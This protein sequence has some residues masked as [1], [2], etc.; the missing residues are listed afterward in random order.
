MHLELPAV[1]TDKLRRYRNQTLRQSLRRSWFHS[2]ASISVSM[3]VL[4]AMDRVVALPPLLRGIFW[5][6]CAV[7]L[8]LGTVRLIRAVM[9]LRS[10]IHIARSI[11]QRDTLFGDH[12][13][14]AIELADS[15]SEQRRSMRLCSAALQQVADEAAKR[16]LTRLLPR[17]SLSISRRLLF[18]SAAVLI[19]FTLFFPHVVTNSMHRVIAPFAAIKRQTLVQLSHLD[20]NIVVPRGEAIRW[21][22]TSAPESRWQPDS[23]SLRLGSLGTINSDRS[24]DGYSF[25]FP[26]LNAPID[27]TLRIGDAT[28]TLHLIPKERPQVNSINATIELPSYLQ[29]SQP[30]LATEPSGNVIEA[31]EGAALTLQVNTSTDLS[32][33]TVDGR[34][35]NAAG[36]SFTV[37][38][39]GD[40]TSVMLDWQ[41]QDGLTADRPITI[42]IERTVDQ[43]PTLIV[44]ETNIPA[45]VLNQQQLR[46]RLTAEDDYAVR[47]VGIQWS[48]EDETGERIVGPGPDG[49]NTTA[50]FNPTAYGVEE[51]DVLIRFWV[52]DDLPER[53]RIYTDAYA[54]T[55]LSAEDHAVWIGDSLARWRQSAIEVRDRELQLLSI[56]QELMTVPESDRDVEWRRR[57]ATQAAAEAENSRRLK[58]IVEDGKAILSQAAANDQIPSGQ[59]EGLAQSI[60]ALTDLAEG[61]MPRVAKLLNDAAQEE[62]KFGAMANLETTQGELPDQEQTSS[63][64]DP[65]GET[66]ASPE[67]LGLADTTVIDTSTSGR[68]TDDEEKSPGSNK[69][70]LAEAVEDQA[71]LVAKF[72]AIADQLKELL[73]QMDGSTLVKRMKAISRIQD[74]VAGRLAK[75]IGDRFGRSQPAQPT[76]FQASIDDTEETISRLQRV[77]DDLQA[78]LK[79][80][81]IRSFKVVF[82]EM[83]NDGVLDQLRL[84]KR[85]LPSSPGASIAAAEFWS[86]NFDRLADDLIEPPTNDDEQ[87]PDNGK[88]KK[89]LDPEVVLE[90]LRIL[91]SEVDLRELTRQAEQ[92]RKAMKPDDYASE[93]IQLSESQDGIRDRLDQVIDRLQTDRDS[94]IQFAAEAEVLSSARA[95][96]VD[97]AETLVQPD[98]GPAVIAAQTEAIELLLRSRKVD[99]S[100]GGGS[101]SASSAGGDTDQAALKLVGDALNELAEIR[102]GEVRTSTGAASFEVPERMRADLDRY[103]FR[104]EQRLRGTAK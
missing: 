96:M 94:A 90:V 53:P 88:P 71:E 40:A 65:D 103:F 38:L 18:A 35:I 28:A 32:D 74:R 43:P 54:L 6:T 20:P 31:L 60:G 57:L 1:L 61:R 12:L 59:L 102:S 97:A 98:T 64:Q 81:E 41:D 39:G 4:V 33:A 36:T 73:G 86:D 24:A 19:V 13:Q 80:R 45:R 77:M 26:P 10:P 93:A 68:K 49:K 48:R 46:F 30:K 8:V 62:S 37:S 67:R 63:D 23:A 21:V 84:L 44:D 58:R 101:N 17:Q 50:F 11:S 72:D 27:A 42:E 5:V 69:K 79:R 16:D 95:A 87:E 34:Q 9:R 29:V 83:R 7:T 22:A 78:F 76:D 66:P 92:G 2:L 100:T 14:G 51:G 82:E 15:A 55:V 99:P 91:K 85:N 104:L 75:T 70:K 3:L 25:E 56:N 47:R 52:E 89:S